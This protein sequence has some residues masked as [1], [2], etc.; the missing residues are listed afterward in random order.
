MSVPEYTDEPTPDRPHRL[1]PLLNEAVLITGVPAVVLAI[2]Y[3]GPAMWALLF[4]LGIIQLGLLA[5]SVSTELPPED[6]PLTLRPGWSALAAAADLLVL[7]ALLLFI[8]RAWFEPATAAVPAPTAS[9]FCAVFS[10]P[11]LGALHHF[12]HTRAVRPAGTAAERG[13]RPG[14]D[15]VRG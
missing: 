3:A 9:G 1:C 11:V 5:L 10:V 13:A 4:Y 14:T 2:A 8:L 7:A 6:A 15:D 12:A